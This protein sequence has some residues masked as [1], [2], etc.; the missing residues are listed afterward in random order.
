MAQ[1]YEGQRVCGATTSTTGTCEKCG[2]KPDPYTAASPSG[3]HG[4]KCQVPGCGGR[5]ICTIPIR[6]DRTVCKRHIRQGTKHEKDANAA[7]SQL[8]VGIRGVAGKLPVELRE[9]YVEIFRNP[10]LL[11]IRN[12]VALFVLRQ[13]ILVER[14]ETGESTALWQSLKDHKSE[15]ESVNASMSSLASRLREMSADDPEREQV[16]QDF[17]AAK[18][19]MESSLKSMF[20]VIDKA[21]D[22]EDNWDELLAMSERV[23]ELKRLQHAR[24]KDLKQMIPA[25][26]AF[27]L[28]GSLVAVIRKTV[29]DKVILAAVEHELV[30]LLRVEGPASLPCRDLA[31]RLTTARESRGTIDAASGVVSGGASGGDGRTVVDDA[32]GE[33]GTNATMIAADPEQAG[34]TLKNS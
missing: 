30:E 3:R 1:I 7:A 18:K 19:A 32:G 12:E 23:A 28:I 29:A 15:F 17:A 16:E 24:L 20:R 14:L 2:W 10:Q 25:E 11:S 21:V 9:R 27:T 26:Q 33:S 4:G 13:E 22:H 34:D 6:G 5:M 8:D 31:G